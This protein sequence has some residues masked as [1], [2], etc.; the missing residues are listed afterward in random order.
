MHLGSDS[1]GP[2]LPLDLKRNIRKRQCVK[3]L[4][5]RVPVKIYCRNVAVVRQSG[6]SLR[7][8]AGCLAHFPSNKGVLGHLSVL[9]F[10]LSE[11]VPKS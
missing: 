8:K 9:D 1:A 11:L 4:I 3:R 5:G 10:F 7:Q 6:S 2:S